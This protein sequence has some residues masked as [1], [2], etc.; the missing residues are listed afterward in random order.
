MKKDRDIY[1]QLGRLL[2]LVVVAIILLCGKGTAFGNPFVHPFECTTNK[3]ELQVLKLLLTE[4]IYK[5][6]YAH[7]K[8]FTDTDMETQWAEVEADA[9]R[10]I[11]ANFRCAA[12]P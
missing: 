3:M 4:R 11:D 7:D 9:K 6:R 5:I 1:Q 8:N 10:I 12:Q 2:F